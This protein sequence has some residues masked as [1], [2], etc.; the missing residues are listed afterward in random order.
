MQ[1][2]AICKTNQ[3]DYLWQPQLESFYLPGYQARGRFITVPVC[4][5]CKEKIK[6][7]ESVQF[8]YKHQQ[9]QASLKSLETTELPKKEEVLST[10]STQPTPAQQKIIE[11]LKHGKNLCLLLSRTEG[12]PDQWYGGELYD[13]Q[14]RRITTGQ[15]VLP[16]T[17]QAMIKKGFITEKSQWIGS[18]GV[19]GNKKHEV[20]HVEYKLKEDGNNHHHHHHN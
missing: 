5:D 11:A 10:S 9:Y 3:Q 4:N 12:E 2:C 7:G 17:I 14:R 16:A 19:R 15:T 6:Q 1:K 8:V 18:T 13:P 20:W